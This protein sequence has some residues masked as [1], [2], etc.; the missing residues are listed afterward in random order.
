[1]VPD[2]QRHRTLTTLRLILPAAM[3]AD[4]M[5]SIEY[6][7]TCRPCMQWDDVAE[8]VLHLIKATGKVLSGPVLLTLLEWAD[9]LRMRNV[10]FIDFIAVPYAT[11][12]GPVM[13]LQLQQ[14]L[15]PV[16]AAA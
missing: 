15:S 1:M 4:A 5:A 12:G 16:V 13:I 11:Q 14:D 3:V 6:L 9:R 7:H 2:Y 8:P 10:D